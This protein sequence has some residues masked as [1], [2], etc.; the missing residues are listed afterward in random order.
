MPVSTT[1][2]SAEASIGIGDASDEASAPAG[3]GSLPQAE[4][5]DVSSV[6]MEARVAMHIASRWPVK[7]S[8][9]IGPDRPVAARSFGTLRRVRTAAFYGVS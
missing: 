6:R 1:L 3:C 2:E 5:V 9:I 7:R 4:M 8:P